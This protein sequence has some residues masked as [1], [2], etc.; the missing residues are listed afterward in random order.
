MRAMNAVLKPAFS[1]L[2]EDLTTVEPL[3][4]AFI[5]GIESKRRLIEIMAARSRPNRWLA[6]H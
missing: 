5:R 3:A 6:A 2:L 1:E 4:G